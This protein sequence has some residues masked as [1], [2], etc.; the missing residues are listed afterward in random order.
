M[1][2]SFYT[3]KNIAI[4]AQNFLSQ[5][6]S[7]RAL[8]HRKFDLAHAALIVIDMQPFFLD[9]TSHAFIPS[10]AATIPIIQK[11]LKYFSQKQRPIVFT[12]H[13][14][15]HDPN[16]NMNRWWGNNKFDNFACEITTELLLPDIKFDTIYKNQYDIF[17]QT[18][19]ENL[20]Q[21]QQITQIVITGLMTH[22]CCDTS[23]R[24]AFMRN[25]DVFTVIDGMSDTNETFHISTLHNLAHICAT[26]LLAKEI[27]DAK[28]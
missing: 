11:L 14:V 17:Y 5:L 20:L 1:K 26:P 13:K 25:F 18:P 19:L 21:Q 28:T 7:L 15:N 12:L 6:L 22:I 16:N 2:E 8:H 24:S 10:A 9:P 3:K 4:K 27:L 23:A